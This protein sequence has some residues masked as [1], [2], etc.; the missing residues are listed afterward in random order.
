MWINDDD[1][2]ELNI[3]KQREGCNKHRDNNQVEKKSSLEKFNG[4]GDILKHC[5]ERES[6][7]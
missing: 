7:V 1:F 3:W 2:A 6:H 4:G 5:F